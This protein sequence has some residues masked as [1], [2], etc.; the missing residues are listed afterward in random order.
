MKTLTKTSVKTVAML[1]LGV[2]VAGSA[3]AKGGDGNKGDKK[4]RGGDKGPKCGEFA[5][6]D[7]PGKEEHKEFREAQ[8]EK[9]KA[10][11]KERQEKMKAAKEAAKNEEDPYKV[12]AS[13]KA[14]HEKSHAEAVTFFGGIQAEGSAFME[15]MFTKYDVPAEKQA[16]IR[17][18]AESRQKQRKEMHQKQHKKLV[19]TLDELAAKE[20][21]TKDDVRNALKKAH[22]GRSGH[23][24]KCKG[25]RKGDGDKKGGKGRRNQ[26]G[27]E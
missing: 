2:M 24:K 18:K 7:M 19:K 21:L 26:G 14:N 25:K 22:K 27:E 10:F 13:V 20:G 1:T 3:I 12:V 15:S 8:H 6:K 11:H 23:G 4:Q 17:K 5:G 9:I 16:E